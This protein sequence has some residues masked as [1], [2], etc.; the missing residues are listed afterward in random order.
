MVG[1]TGNTT[2]ISSTLSPCLGGWD[3]TYLVFFFFFLHCPFAYTGL[4]EV[5]Q[6]SPPWVFASAAHSSLCPP[7]LRGF[8]ETMDGQGDHG[9]PGMTGVPFSKKQPNQVLASPGPVTI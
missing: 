5:D 8:W 3:V 6:I 1:V 9:Q 4:W 7:S 2:L